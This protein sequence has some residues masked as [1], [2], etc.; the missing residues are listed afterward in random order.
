M[1]LWLCINDPLHFETHRSRNN[2]T[3]YNTL[4]ECATGAERTTT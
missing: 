3:V 2:A 1:M 4:Q